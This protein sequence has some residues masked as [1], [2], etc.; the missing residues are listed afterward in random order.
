MSQRLII[1]LGSD[2][3][4]EARL[5]G[6]RSKSHLVRIPMSVR[7]LEV[8]R[9]LLMHRRTDTK[10]R[11]GQ[12]NQ[13]TQSMIDDWLKNNEIKKVTPTKCATKTSIEKLTTRINKMND[14]ERTALIKLL[15]TNGGG[16]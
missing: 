11:I 9:T 13:P 16:E 4:L 3:Q 14:E 8:L 5:I 12:D 10:P 1:Q 6:G 7:G 15:D 2:D